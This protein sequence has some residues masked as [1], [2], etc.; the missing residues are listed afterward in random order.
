M[1]I[2]EK[3]GLVYTALFLTVSVAVITQNSDAIM[4]AFRG[5]ANVKAVDDIFTVRAGRDQ[6]LFVLRNDVNAKTVTA[7]T[8]NLISQPKCGVVAK[9]GASFMYSGSTS[10]SGRQDFQYCIN[11]GRICETA[12]V[13][14]RIVEARDPVDSVVSG[15]ITD[16]AGFDAQVSIN[17]S[18]LEITNV[19]LGRVAVGETTFIPASGTKLARVA[20]ETPITFHRPA[21]IANNVSVDGVFEM[22]APSSF[23]GETQAV[24]EVKADRDILT[25]VDPVLENAPIR[26][27]QDPAMAGLAALPGAYAN[28]LTARMI[29]IDMGFQAPTV[30]AAIDSSP[31]GTAC[32][33]S[34]RTKALSG[35][36]VK[37]TLKAPCAPNSRVALRHGKLI[38]TLKTSHSGNLT[39]IIPAFEK[40]AHFYIG[41][42]DGT[43]LKS[44]LLV[45]GL[46]HVDRIAI[47]WSGP[48]DVDLHALEFGAPEKTAT[49]LPVSQTIDQKLADKFGGGFA[50]R[51]GDASVE[52]PFQAEIYSLQ[53][54][55]KS[56]SGVVQLVASAASNPGVCGTKQV[57]HSYRSKAGRLVGAS[58]LQFEMP[59]CGGMMQSIVLNNAVRDLIIAAK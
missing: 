30:A 53:S 5:E 54:T 33:S 3:M 21:P 41:L 22:D 13:A 55:T 44:T 39:E 14:L 4:A 36:L 25:D 49:D 46:E 40:K 59:A 38:V 50:V 7:Q 18:D 31:F 37:I 28:G 57:L 9:T 52:N 6:R 1:R 45:P 15:P 42:P 51:L 17:S 47:Q 43:V 24:A 2:N 19:R 58:G 12:S 20:V 27:P 11:T 8:I 10:C 29:E 26:L 34:L 16:L 56:R 48:F 23:A 35:G 32:E